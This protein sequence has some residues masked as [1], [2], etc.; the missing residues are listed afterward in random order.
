MK[1]N[2]KT[3]IE[4][5]EIFKNSELWK[6]YEDIDEVL[7]K[8]TVND[9]SPITGTEYEDC[10]KRDDGKYYIHEKSSKSVDPDDLNTNGADYYYVRMQDSGGG[11]AWIGPIW[12]EVS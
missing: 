2:K 11:A 12:V 9:T 1:P 3:K 7:T 5:I 10:I 8:I 4:E 6:S